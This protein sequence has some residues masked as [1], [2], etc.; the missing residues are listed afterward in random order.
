MFAEEEDVSFFRLDLARRLVDATI[1]HA[2]SWHEVD[3]SNEWTGRALELRAQAL[4]FLN[5]GIASPPMYEG[6]LAAELHS[7]AWSVMDWPYNS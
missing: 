2:D 4:E 3:P 6:F 7:L 1:P 5:Q